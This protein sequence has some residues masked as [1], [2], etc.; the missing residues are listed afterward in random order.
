M[1]RVV[2]FQFEAV[3]LSCFGNGGANL[4]CYKLPDEVESAVIGSYRVHCRC[5]RGVSL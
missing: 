4:V 2:P 1:F 3:A 5:R